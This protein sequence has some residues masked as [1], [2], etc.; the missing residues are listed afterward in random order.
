L[1]WNDEKRGVE[2]RKHLKE[3]YKVLVKE[4]KILHSDTQILA[5]ATRKQR[6]DLPEVRV[7]TYEHVR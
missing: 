5:D 2:K 3:E 6:V 7:H 1:L 4:E